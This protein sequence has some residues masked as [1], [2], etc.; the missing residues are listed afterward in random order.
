MDSALQHPGSTREELSSPTP[1]IV[2]VADWK[3]STDPR[4]H[5]ITY[6]LGSCLGITFHDP[7][8]HIGGLLHALLP[9]SRLHPDKVAQ[10]AMFIDS[11]V[12]IA[13]EAMVKAG[14]QRQD[15]ECKV[16][17]GAQGSSEDYFRIGSKNIDAFAQLSIEHSLKVSVW[18]VSGSVNRTIRLL[19]ATGEVQV[20]LPGQPAFNR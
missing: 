2:G 16:F 20:K 14:A 13:I 5:L 9:E 17:G 4:A 18:E 12:Q 1:I 15:L 8:R 19:N 3:L 7:V 10:P 11:G 6:A